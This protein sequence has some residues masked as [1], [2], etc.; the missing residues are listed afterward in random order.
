M[1]DDQMT[2][3]RLKP[4]LRLRYSIDRGWRPGVWRPRYQDQRED[5]T[6]MG[7][8]RNTG[9]AVGPVSG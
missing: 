6:F 1:L 2:F 7:R 4:K 8:L 5:R 3:G 9:L